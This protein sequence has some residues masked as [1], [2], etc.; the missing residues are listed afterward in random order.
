MTDHADTADG[1]VAGQAS[2]LS[3]ANPAPAPA[4]VAIAVVAANGVIGDGNDQPFKFR[5]DWA[6]F[7]RVTMGHPLVMG[8]RTH[9]A[10]GMLP[11]RTNV[12]VSRSPQDVVWPDDAPADS[13]GVAVSDLGQA[14]GLAGGMD[15]QIFVIGGGQIY[16]A[17]WDWLTDLD[18]TEVHQ[19]AA[20]SVSF[21]EITSEQWRETSREPHE[22]FDFVHYARVGAARRV[23]PTGGAVNSAYAPG[24]AVDPAT[25][26]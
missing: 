1:V 26:D 18:I 8:R 19:D 2:Q 23:V 14:L 3:Q 22:L 24:S 5:E 9:D 11:G 4:V 7:K 21:P 16:R 12:V 25:T 13:R 6:R 20:G 15:E 17:A 10:M